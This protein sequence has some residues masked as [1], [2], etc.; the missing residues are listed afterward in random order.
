MG[1]LVLIPYYE[2][3]CLTPIPDPSPVDGENLRVIWMIKI[4]LLTQAPPI[5]R[6]SFA[7]F[8]A[9]RKLYHSIV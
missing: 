3:G 4:V 9:L 7:L 5:G 1:F 6:S 2:T 8:D